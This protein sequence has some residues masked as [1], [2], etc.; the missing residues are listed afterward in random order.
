VGVLTILLVAAFAIDRIVAGLFFLLSFSGDLRPLLVEDPE[1]PNAR[2]ARTRRLIYAMVAGYL[3]VVVIAGILNVHLFEMAA[4]VDI[5]PASDATA[6]ALAVVHPSRLLDILLTGMILAAGADRI[7][8]IV[9]SF[10]SG[11]DVARKSE[12]KPLTITGKLI[13]ERPGGQAGDPLGDI[14]ADE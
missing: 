8:D 12:D 10:G 5:A 14:R 11:A 9:K 13:L 2:S 7:S 4:P 6:T 1:H 3:G